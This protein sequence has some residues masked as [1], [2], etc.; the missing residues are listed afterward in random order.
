M[1]KNGSLLLSIFLV[2]ATIG[3]NNLKWVF[4]SAL[5]GSG[6]KAATFFNLEKQ[7][8]PSYSLTQLVMENNRPD[9]AFF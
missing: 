8:I 3:S 2:V 5:T 6:L 7:F 9:D 4:P 1:L